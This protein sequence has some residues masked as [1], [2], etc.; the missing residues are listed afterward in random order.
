MIEFWEGQALY[1]SVVHVLADGPMFESWV[2][3]FLLVCASV[4]KCASLVATTFCIISIYDFMHVSV[5]KQAG[6]WYICGDM[7][8]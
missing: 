3:V 2:S 4:Y 1:I 8:A 7:C 5:H 6:I